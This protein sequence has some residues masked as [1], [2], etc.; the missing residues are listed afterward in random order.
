MKATGNDRFLSTTDSHLVTR[1]MPSGRAGLV[2][3]P[4][5]NILLAVITWWLDG[6]LAFGKHRKILGRLRHDWCF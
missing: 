5:L 2:M 4:R 6:M 1:I 3:A